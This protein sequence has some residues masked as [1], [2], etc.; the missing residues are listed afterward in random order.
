MI[1][2]LQVLHIM[3]FLTLGISAC[4]VPPLIIAIVER[5]SGLFP[6]TSSVLL[7]SSIGGI[8]LYLMSGRGGDAL[9]HR[10]SLL[11][12]SL[13]WV[14]TGALGAMP[15]YLS[16]A[17][18]SFTDALFE[19]VSGFTTTGASVLP[20]VEVLPASLQFWR[21]FTHWLGGLGVILL[22]IAVLP[23]LGH[24]SVFLY[25]AEFSGAR[26]DKLKPRIAETAAALWKIY[27][28][29]T[30][31]GY[32]VLRILGLS[33]LDAIF[34]TFAAIGTGGFST[35]NSNVEAFNSVAVELVLIVLMVVGGL[36]FTLH[37]RL[38]VLRQW[39]VFVRDSEV[40]L[41]FGLLAVAVLLVSLSLSSS[42][43]TSWWHSVRLSA[44]QV[45]S[46]M[47]A[48]GFSSADFDQWTAFGKFVLLTL[49]FVGGCTGST[50][51]GLKVARIVLLLKSV[52]RQMET[53]LNR[54]SVCIVRLSGEPVQ[55]GLITTALGLVSLAIMLN[56]GASLAVAATGVDLITS[57]SGVTACMFNVGPGLGAVGPAQNY[58]HLSLFAKW[59]LIF[60]M[61]AG[62][63]EFF[64]F[65]AVFTPS[66]WRR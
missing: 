5:D 64:V 28:G 14:I 46:I 50:A 65:L 55:P 52:G 54:K 22:M 51:G 57:F 53:M 66:F 13:A 3:L 9:S 18:A 25:R 45:V 32:L 40:R 36:N 27:I 11:V 48:T 21:G 1:R 7:T 59:V 12:V 6:L 30:V 44:F 47:T 2:W 58:G 41:Y 61:V 43:G 20:A 39:R 26:S 10:G 16:P 23:L 38:I 49:M 62:R 63:L 60:V 35:R 24:G 15:F 34:H 17:F 4:L 33:R 37:F 29:F 31:A 19:S 8:G 42:M 56:M